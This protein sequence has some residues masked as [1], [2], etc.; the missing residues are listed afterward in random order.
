METFYL[1]SGICSILS[2]LLTIFISTQIIKINKSTNQKVKG[3]NNYTY[4]NN[5]HG[6]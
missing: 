2:L 6:E 3:D 1:I 5:K 4:Q